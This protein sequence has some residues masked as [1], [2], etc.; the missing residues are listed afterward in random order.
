VPLAP[1]PFG[2]APEPSDY[3]VADDGTRVAVYDFGGSGPDLLL[4]HATGFCA[5]VLAPLASALGDRFSCWALDLRAH[6]R[7]DPPADLDF[8]W[9]GF[10]A[11]VAAAVALLGLRRSLA[12][13]HSCGGAS[14]VLA[15]EATPGTFA[16]L[17]CFEPVILRNPPV[18]GPMDDNPL[19]AGARRRRET[20]PS[21]EDAFVNF[22]GKMPFKELDPDVL[23]LYVEAGLE[24]VPPGDG[25]DGHEVRL[26]CR[27]E[28]EAAVY[29]WAPFHSAFAG[30]GGVGCPVTLVCG[31]ETDSFPPAHL[32]RL[33][34]RL[35]LARVEVLPGLGHFG[36][37]Q[38]PPAVARSVGLA[39][40][41]SDTPGP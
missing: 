26:R 25:G 22:A 24:P 38:D 21:A 3:A 7:S 10:G 40:P 28:H 17:Y 6:G 11:D 12:V 8:R 4:V 36:P 35:P 18:E 27:R 1:A 5:A 13:G 19:S 29:A 34:A 31:A 32:D 39:F 41:E 37:L 15:E 16:A 2:P 23:R 20:F 30:L 9:A 14:V 33:A